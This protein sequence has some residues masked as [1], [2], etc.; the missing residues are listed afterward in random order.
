MGAG[1]RVPARLGAPRGREA[2]VSHAQ[3]LASKQH[4]VSPQGLA[5]DG[6]ADGSILTNFP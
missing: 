4:E 5:V 3:G 1:D 6:L 2:G